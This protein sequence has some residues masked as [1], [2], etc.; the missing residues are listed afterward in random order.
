MVG[1][2]IKV[3]WPLQLCPLLAAYPSPS[4]NSLSLFFPQ[5]L[6]LPVPQLGTPSW[7]GQSGFR[8]MYRAGSTW[9]WAL[10]SLFWEEIPGECSW[11]PTSGMA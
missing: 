1:P 7:V 9:E 5:A 11:L 6:R 4:Y 8:G 3:L 10:E 2:K